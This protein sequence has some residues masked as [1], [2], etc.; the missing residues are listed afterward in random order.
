MCREET[1]LPVGGVSSLPAAFLINQLLDVMQVPLPP[2]PKSV[3]LVTE[4][5]KGRGPLV[6]RA[7]LRPAALLRD[8]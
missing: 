7:P 8:V 4:T 2:L 6:Y 5:A 3:Y 1:F